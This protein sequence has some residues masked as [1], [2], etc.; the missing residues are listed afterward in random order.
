MHK[1]G[2]Y[3]CRDNIVA[4]LKWCS[5]LQPSSYSLASLYATCQNLHTVEIVKTV[6]I[7]TSKYTATYVELPRCISKL[8]AFNFGLKA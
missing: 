5:F 8:Q 7:P 4:S 3:E 6:N 2:I 1:D